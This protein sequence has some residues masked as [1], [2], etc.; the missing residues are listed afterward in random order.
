MID[1]IYPNICLFCEEKTGQ[2]CSDKL[3]EFCYNILAPKEKLYKGCMKCGLPVG[4]HYDKADCATCRNRAIH[5]DQ[6]YFVG[7][8]HSGLMDLVHRFKYAKDKLLVYPFAEEIANQVSLDYDVITCVPMHWVKKMIRGFNQSEILAYEIAKFGKVAFDNRLLKRK[9]YGKKQA[10]TNK[11]ERLINVRKLYELGRRTLKPNK[12]LLVD[13][14]C[15][16][17]S[18]LSACAKVLKSGGVAQ[19][20]ALVLAAVHKKIG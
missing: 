12:V 8:Y 9:L 6:L 13:D 7:E 10:G 20:D 14:V 19:V 17:G 2:F 3:C 18:T 5:Y 15:T 4:L 16:T 1:L 11:T